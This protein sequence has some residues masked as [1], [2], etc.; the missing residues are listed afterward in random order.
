MKTK[1]SLGKG[2]ESELVWRLIKQ[3]LSWSIVCNGKGPS[4]YCFSYYPVVRTRKVIFTLK[5]ALIPWWLPCLGFA[6]A[7]GGLLY[8]FS[9]CI[10]IHSHLNTVYEY[11]G[12]LGNH[13]MNTHVVYLVAWINMYDWSYGTD[14]RAH[15]HYLMSE[16][17]WRTGQ[18][19]FRL[20]QPCLFQIRNIPLLCFCLG[21]S[22]IRLYHWNRP[23]KISHILPA[24]FEGLLMVKVQSRQCWHK[25][26]RTD[27]NADFQICFCHG[28]SSQRH[29][30]ENHLLNLFRS[31]KTQLDWSALSLM[32][33]WLYSPLCANK[34]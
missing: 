9:H 33:P 32:C 15:K 11:R 29:G 22:L 5:R 24:S 16:M 26:E 20:L 2:R 28:K 13:H 3:H 18:T 25:Y 23:A 6:G 27:Q 12:V 14:Y 34:T 7:T 17:L 1:W 4:R 21:S 8:V 10:K 30:F 31:L 19:P